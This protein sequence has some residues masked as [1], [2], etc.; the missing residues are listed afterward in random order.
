MTDQEILRELAN[1]YMEAANE[2]VNAERRERAY[3]TNGLQAVRPLVWIHELPWHELNID[4]ALTLR[5]EGALAREIEQFLRR[6]LLQWRYFQAD[7]ILE[8]Y[9]PVSMCIHSTGI[10]FQVIEEVLVGDDKNNIISHSYKDQLDSLEKL[11]I[12]HN[13]VV[14][15]DYDEEKKRVSDAQ[16]LLGDAMPV[17]LCPQNMYYY[18]PWD[19]VCRM[20]GM[21]PLL[22]DLAAEPEL[23]HATIQKFSSV[24]NADIDALNAVNAF[25]VSASSLHAAVFPGAG[26]RRGKGGA[27]RPQR[28]VPRARAAL[29][30]GLA[31]HARRVRHSVS[32]AHR[33][34]IRPVLLWLLRAA[35]RPNRHSQA[36]PEPSKG[37]RYTVVERGGLRGE[38][39][40]GLC[41]LAQAE[42]GHGR[43]YAGRGCGSK[44]HCARHGSMP[45]EQLPL[46]I[47]AQ[48]YFHRRLQAAKHHP[49][50]AGRRRNDRQILLRRR[51][52]NEVVVRRMLL[53]L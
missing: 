40:E 5:C 27:V 36:D 43:D 33:Q 42:S 4:D 47:R 12:L 10:G 29:R 20:R 18:A 16:A 37:R 1:A 30:R 2:P 15:R 3:A 49:L 14:T 8:P 48:G 28:V 17:K 50:G 38:A 44:G 34:E 53:A 9:Y 31:R 11:E 26:G 39:R 25:G 46:R 35:V 6:S 21:T 51:R 13:P 7:M 32:S 23:M 19:R 24:L 41:V 22:M 45:E 52:T